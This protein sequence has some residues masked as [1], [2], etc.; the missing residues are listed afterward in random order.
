M[1]RRDNCN[2][3]FTKVINYKKVACTLI[4]KECF[5]DGLIVD[6]QVD[7][8]IN[9]DYQFVFLN[10]ATVKLLFRDL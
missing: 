4:S 8:V 7:D 10:K 3:S 1:V 5:I 9:T 2:D 6:T